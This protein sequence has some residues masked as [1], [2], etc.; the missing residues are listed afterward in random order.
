MIDKNMAIELFKQGYSYQE[1]G[2]KFNVS[3]QRIHQVVKD[4]RNIGRRGRED[5]YRDFGQC[6]RC[7]ELATVLHH[8]DLN[9]SNDDISNLR[10]LCHKCHM[11]KHTNTNK[12]LKPKTSPQYRKFLLNKNGT[13]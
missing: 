12:T 10:A 11:T 3:R 5:K 6:N 9:N 8:I 1:I 7:S 2:N 13:V 4:Y